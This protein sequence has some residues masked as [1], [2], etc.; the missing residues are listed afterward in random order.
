[1]ILVGGRA[2]VLMF[3]VLSTLVKFS[4]SLHSRSSASHKEESS[5]LMHHPLIGGIRERMLNPNSS[6]ISANDL[7]CWVHTLLCAIR[8]LL[9]VLRLLGQQI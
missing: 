7:V 1:M 4:I 9:M 2:V 6:H 3:M 5:F 8:P